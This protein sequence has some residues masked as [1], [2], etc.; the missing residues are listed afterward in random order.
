VALGVPNRSQDEPVPR[1]PATFSSLS[2]AL[3]S[4]YAT[5]IS[6][7]LAWALIST[8]E[9]GAMRGGDVEHIAIASRP[10]R[11]SCQVLS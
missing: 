11:G 5:T 4:G 8:L 7:L 6:P 9:S 3:W 2:M 1:V 10:R